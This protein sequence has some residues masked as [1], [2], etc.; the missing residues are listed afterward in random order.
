[1][2]LMCFPIII[3]NDNIVVLV[4]SL[5]NGKM[6]AYDNYKGSLIIHAHKIKFKMLRIILYMEAIIGILRER[7]MDEHYCLKSIYIFF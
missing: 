5:R 2:L 1:M 6:Q 4:Y 7:F 3:G